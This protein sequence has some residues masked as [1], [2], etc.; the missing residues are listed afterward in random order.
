MFRRR[1]QAGAFALWWNAHGLSYGIPSSVHDS[2]ASGH[3]VIANLSRGKLV[4][5]QQTFDQ[6]LVLSIS[7]SSQVLAQRLEARGRESAQDRE[8]RLAR[9]ALPLPGG[10]PVIE[11]DNSGAL[12][13]AVQAALAG[14]TAPQVASA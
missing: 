14:L 13:D 10:L 4:E 8:K 5:A 6:F 11:I 9:A 1:A 2:L 12:D 3:D 7:A